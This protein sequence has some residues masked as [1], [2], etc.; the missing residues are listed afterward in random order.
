[1]REDE[2]LVE[3]TERMVLRFEKGREKGK[4]NLGQREGE[5]TRVAGR[6]DRWH[7]LGKVCSRSFQ[8]GH[9]AWLHGLLQPQLV[10]PRF[11]R[12]WGLSGE[13]YMKARVTRVGRRGQ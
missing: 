7:F 9:S 10:S 3:S 13:K 11:N 1:M 2:S 12:G 8:D 6:T 5:I 4:V